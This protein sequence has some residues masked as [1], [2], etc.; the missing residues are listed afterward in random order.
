MDTPA[1]TDQGQIATKT[2]TDLKKPKLY[3]VLLLNDDYTTMEFV[4][5][6]LKL[7]FGKNE[8]EAMA[9]MLAIHHEGSGICGVY[10]HE[11]AETKVSK[12]RQ[13]SK[14]HQFPLRCEMEEEW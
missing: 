1:S 3:K 2:K 13:I 11:I 10:T 7:I 12:V 9:I 6:I 14:E 8:E 4:V 5:H